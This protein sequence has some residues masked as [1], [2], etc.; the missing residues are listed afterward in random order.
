MVQ[1]TDEDDEEVTFKEL[2][3][4]YILMY[5]KRVKLDKFNKMLRKD[6]QDI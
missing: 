4:K 5:T 2:Q 1:S 3:E 6:L